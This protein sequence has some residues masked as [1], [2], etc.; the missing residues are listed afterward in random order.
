[1][2]EISIME[3]GLNHAILKK[4]EAILLFYNSL[5]TAE[6]TQRGVTAW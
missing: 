1:M 3:V 5:S 4:N 2:E 6:V